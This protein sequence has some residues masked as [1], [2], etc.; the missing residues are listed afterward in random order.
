MKRQTLILLSL[1][2]GL[3][4][5]ANAAY[6]PIGQWGCTQ[7][8][9]IRQRFGVEVIGVRRTAHNFML[10]FRF[11]VVDKE[12]SK[13]LFDGSKFPV[14]TSEKTGAKVIVPTPP[15]VGQ[16]RQTKPV[17]AGKTC[18]MVFANPHQHIKRGDLVTIELGDF[19]VQ[20]LVVE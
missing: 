8:D 15:K 1:L 10:D 2:M 4:L 3:A 16:L 11:R 17:E 12:L 7:E 20:H 19:K 13:P 14:L 18:F 6:L 5:F 9:D